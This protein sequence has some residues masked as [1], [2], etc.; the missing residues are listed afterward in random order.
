MG[1]LFFLKIGYGDTK[2]IP[3]LPM[4]K[5]EALVTKAKCEGKAE[6]LVG[7]WNDI[8]EKIYSLSD[9]EKQLGLGEKVL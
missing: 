5:F 4:D 7:K 8:K 6:E 2:V 3:G 1:F 9:R